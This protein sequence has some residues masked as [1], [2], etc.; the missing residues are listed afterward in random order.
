MVMVVRV[1]SWQRTE[2]KKGDAETLRDGQSV[3]TWEG[4]CV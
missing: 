2:E 1:N 3:N 4:V